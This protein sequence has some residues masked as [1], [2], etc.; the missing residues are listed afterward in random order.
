MKRFS[1]YT[2]SDYCTYREDMA[3]DIGARVFGGSGTADEGEAMQPLMDL[4]REIWSLDREGVLNFFNRYKDDPRAEGTNIAELIDALE[5]GKSKVS[6]TF[7]KNK[8]R[9]PD[10]IVPPDTDMD[11]G[12]NEGGGE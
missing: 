4:I 8:F 6:S 3:R 12:D 11:G 7:N 9:E 5:S 1:N 10:Q 2:F